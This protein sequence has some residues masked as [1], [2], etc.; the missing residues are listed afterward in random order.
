MNSIILS[1]VG[2]SIFTKG[3]FPPEINKFS[4]CKKLE[5]IPSDQREEIS[6]Y[7][8]EV[9]NCCCLPLWKM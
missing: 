2:T 6:S 7:I 9:N 4:N 5:E 8:Q 1:P 3:K